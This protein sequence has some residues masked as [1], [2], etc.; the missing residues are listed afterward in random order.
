MPMRRHFFSRREEIE[1]LENYKTELER[2]LDGVKE[3]IESL[4]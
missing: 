1:L 4:Q 3:K 2:E